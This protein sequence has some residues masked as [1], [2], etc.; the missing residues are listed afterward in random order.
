MQH[1]FLPTAPAARHPFRQALVL[2]RIEQART[3]DENDI[4]LFALAFSAFFICFYTFIG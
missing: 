2:T 1:T 3:Q 4:K